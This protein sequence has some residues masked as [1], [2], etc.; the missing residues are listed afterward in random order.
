VSRVNQTELADILGVNDTTLWEWQKEGM[1]ILELGGSGKPNKYDTA[2]VVAWIRARDRRTAPKTTRDALA[3]IELKLKQMDLD[4]R[5]GL[6]VP[7]AEVKPLW[8]SYVFTAAAFMTGRHSRLAAILE[9]APGIEAKRELLK[10]EDANFLTKLGGDGERMQNEVVA[11]LASLPAEDASAFLRRIAG[12]DD[13]QLHLVVPADR[14]ANPTSEA[15]AAAG[16]RDADCGESP[17]I[18][19]AANK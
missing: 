4:E 3:E 10:K 2:A 15:P 5:Q 6:L 14:Q 18:A 12:D 11:L 9:A 7:A 8:D 19:T 17:A 13:T 16:T 1:P